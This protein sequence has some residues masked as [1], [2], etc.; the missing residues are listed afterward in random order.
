MS[1]YEATTT[2]A[3]SN[4]GSF[5]KVEGEEHNPITSAAENTAAYNVKEEDGVE[6]TD[7]DDGDIPDTGEDENWDEDEEDDEDDEDE[8]EDEDEDDA[9][10][11]R[12]GIENF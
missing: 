9:E 2:N 5:V 10:Y 6:V 3:L 1:D 11:E 8:D 12:K 4:P 7:E